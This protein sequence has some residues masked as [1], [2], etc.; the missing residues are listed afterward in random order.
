VGSEISPLLAHWFLDK[1]R[2]PYD[3]SDRNRWAQSLGVSVAAID[4]LLDSDVIDLHIDAFIWSRI[5]GYDLC[6]WHDRGPLF[7]RYL[8]QTD[9]PRLNA[10]GIAGAI[11][12]I[13]TNPWR[14]SRNKLRTLLTNYSTLSQELAR[15]EANT[16]LVHSYAE[17][18]I[19]RAAGKHAAFIAVQGGDALGD[20]RSAQVFPL[21]RLLLVTLVHMTDNEFGHSSS[22][23]S[24]RQKLGLRPQGHELIAELEQRRVWLDLAHASKTTFWDAVHAHDRTCPLVVTHTGFSG[25]TPHWRNLDDDQATAIVN[26]GG[27][28][29]VLFHGPYLGDWA[30]GGTVTSIARHLA[31]GIQRFGAEHICLGSD[32]DGMIA[33]P[34]DMPT[35]LELPRLVQAL[36]DQGVGELSITKVLGESF[37]RLLR[38][39]RNSP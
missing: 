6:R 14:R 24:F 3:A 22:P 10:A 39:T 19:A 21:E 9:L 13:T 2:P 27:I 36:L 31:Y 25:V 8:S 20:P 16:T 26:S 23:L 37:L 29:G 35:C 18:R 4:L 5:F 7:A 1:T 33:T 11:W 34:L 17:Y 32:W 12:S 38:Q 15:P 28:I 30:W